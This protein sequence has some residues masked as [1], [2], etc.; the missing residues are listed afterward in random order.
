MLGGC[1]ISLRKDQI[2]TSV[3]LKKQ[4]NYTESEVGGVVSKLRGVFTAQGEC[5]YVIAMVY[6]TT[7]EPHQVSSDR[8]AQISISDRIASYSRDSMIDPRTS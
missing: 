1:N 5:Q 2:Y 6:G 4:K 3:T 8:G 7:A